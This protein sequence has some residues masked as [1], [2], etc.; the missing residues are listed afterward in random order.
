MFKQISTQATAFGL[1]ALVTLATLGSM[2]ALANHSVAT[3]MA[4][5]DSTPVQQVVIVGKRDV[6]G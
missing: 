1:A 5:A 4:R 3:E 6:R 2:S